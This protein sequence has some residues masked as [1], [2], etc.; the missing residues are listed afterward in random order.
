[1]T[2]T[3]PPPSAHH[4]D[5]LTRFVAAAAAAA[6][7]PA[8][9]QLVAGGAGY[10]EL[11]RQLASAPGSIPGFAARLE[12]ACRQAQV[13]AA[14]LRTR[15]LPVARA[16]RLADGDEGRPDH[17]A[18]LGLTPAADAAAVKRAY[19]RRAR[20][21][22]PD[23]GGAADSQAFAELYA[24]YHTL[25]DAGRR[26]IYDGQTRSGAGW[27]ETVRRP[28][29]PARRGP[30]LAGLGLTLALLVAA[31]FVLDA[32]DR[33]EALRRGPSWSP[34]GGGAALPVAEAPARPTPAEVLRT[35]ALAPEPAPAAEGPALQ[36]Q[37]YAP[38]RETEGAPPAIAAAET[39]GGAPSRG[40]PAPL[41]AE[42]PARAARL[43]V[44]IYAAGPR[45]DE[46][47]RRLAQA[48]AAAGYDR[49]AVHPVVYARG[50]DVRYFHDADRPRARDVQPFV[51]EALGDA[52]GARVP[53]KNL[54][55]RFPGAPTGRIE[56]WLNPPEPPAAAE[57]PP[58]A[59]PPVSA[60]AASEDGRDRAGRLRAFLA[61]YCQAYA[62]KD[63]ESFAAFFLPEALENG[64]PFQGLLPRYRQ[65]LARIESL[66]YRID[67]ARFA[68]GPENRGLSLEGT[69]RA[70]CRLVGAEVRESRGTIAMELVEA[71]EG[72][73]VRRLDYRVQAERP[74]HGSAQDS[75]LRTQDGV[76]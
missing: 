34:S 20:D 13:D 24:A 41:A 67:L 74:D 45:G 7:T 70:R 39:H 31:A 50:N 36:F 37:N 30:F 32:Y 3:S 40:A 64:E 33:E 27:R 28:A 65:N 9:I 12:A 52:A 35:S 38:G 29:A 14:S 54:A 72:F 18:V 48:L 1:M 19:R 59:P 57:P 69:F 49:P 15:L 8:L 4:P 44:A 71:G 66:D 16:L 17:Y 76:W 46:A 42:A 25:G 63:L 47:A 73:R 21:L 22:H 75:R 55:R 6:D 10:P 23:S 5:R 11:C 53:L 60:A 2:I 58:A 26:R 43:R 68:E 61:E 51:A 62:A 56:I